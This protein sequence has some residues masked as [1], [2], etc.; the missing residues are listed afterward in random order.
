M[1]PN[2]LIKLYVVERI[3]NIGFPRIPLNFQHHRVGIAVHWQSLLRFFCGYPN[4][5]IA[6][7]QKLK[8]LYSVYSSEALKL[9][10][11]PRHR[12]LLNITSN[13]QLTRNVFIHVRHRFTLEHT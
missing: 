5:Q 3:R 1:T 12:S 8:L 6:F 10:R 2:Q 4:F 7:K 13:L 11:A 9:H